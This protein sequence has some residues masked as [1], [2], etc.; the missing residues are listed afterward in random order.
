M[1]EISLTDFVDFV[2]KSGSPKLTKVKS[3]K[4]RPDYDPKTDYWKSL[5]D[6]IVRVSK[7]KAS[8]ASLDSLVSASSDAKKARYRECAKGFKKFLGTKPTIWVPPVSSLWEAGGLEV[9]VNPEIGL[10]IKGVPHLIKLHFK[11]EKLSKIRV[12]SVLL[13]MA[14]ALAGKAKPGTHFGILDVPRAKLFT[15]KDGKAE[16]L[17]L[18]VGEATAFAE[19][20]D[21]V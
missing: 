1:A 6:G 11:A 18:L 8:K 17:P 12:D 21:Q 5:R 9:R 13:L 7:G 15:T 16:L 19:I 4:T 10:K 20:W 2:I 3:A 14:Q